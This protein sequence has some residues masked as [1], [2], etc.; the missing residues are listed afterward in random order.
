MGINID[1]IRWSGRKYDTPNSPLYYWRLQRNN[2]GAD[3]FRNGGG[4]N[5]ENP[6]EKN[7][8]SFTTSDRGCRAVTFQ[9]DFTI[10]CNIQ[11]N[12]KLILQEHTC[13]TRRRGTSRG[14]SCIFHISVCG[15]IRRIGR[16]WLLLQLCRILLLIL[17]RFT[18]IYNIWHY[19]LLVS[20]DKFKY[21]YGTLLW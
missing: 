8:R 4:D 21:V 2:F 16:V 3:E 13:R 1:Y 10:A 17:W 5:G 20:S 12:Y 18:Q 7:K 11:P 14:S 15:R 9:D 6:K 19:T